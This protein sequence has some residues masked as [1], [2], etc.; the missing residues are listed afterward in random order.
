LARFLPDKTTLTLEAWH[1]DDTAAQITLDVTATPARV[2]CPLCHVPTARIH[3]RDV[4][5]LADLPWGAYHVCLRL[6]VRKFVCGNTTCPRQIFTERLPSVAAPWAR[7]T[8]RLAER[9][10]ALGLALGGTAGTRLTPHFGLPTSRDTLLRMVRGVPLPVVPPLSAIGVDDWAHRKRQRYGT[11]VVDME[12]RR[13]VAL[14]NDREADTLATWL[15]A[16][17]GVPVSTRDRMKA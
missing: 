5:C 10:R 8:L 12:R 16:H 17:P 13:P 1:V 3:S 11:I 4:R 2:P 14:L 6:R 7:R 9:L 15:R